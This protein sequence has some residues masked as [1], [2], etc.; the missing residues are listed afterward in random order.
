MN[1]T[2][3]TIPNCPKCSAAKALLKRKGIEFKEIDVVKENTTNTQVEGY[4]GVFP[5]IMLDDKRIEGVMAL[6][7]EIK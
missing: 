3:Y 4:V 2:V 7:E 1:A 6:K 5:V